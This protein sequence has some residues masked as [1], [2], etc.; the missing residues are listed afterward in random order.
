[1][2]L[3]LTNFLSQLK[4]A[5]LIQ[6]KKLIVK[7][8]PSFLPILKIL[9]QEGFILSY[10]KQNNKLMIYLRYFY[11]SSNLKH[12]KIVSTISKPIYLNKFDISKIIEKNKLLIFSTP[13]GIL[14]S[15]ECKK[16]GIGGIFIFAC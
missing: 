10:I 15:I 16:I 3:I 11:N 1:M 9:Y 4:N 13:K 6:K 5:S 8:N 7:F 14:S 2:N 12:L